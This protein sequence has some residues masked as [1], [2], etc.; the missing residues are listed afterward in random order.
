[1]ALGLGLLKTFTAQEVAV[2]RALVLGAS[3]SGLV[4]QAECANHLRPSVGT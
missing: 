3:P 4:P 1:M 2:G